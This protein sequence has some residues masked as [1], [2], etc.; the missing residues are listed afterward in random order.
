MT[1]IV[2]K[3]EIINPFEE[4]KKQR[5]R[6]LSDFLSRQKMPIDYYEVTSLLE[7]KYGIK[8]RTAKDYL[9]VVMIQQKLVQREG[10]I[11]KTE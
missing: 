4:A 8:L 7:A 9:R 10:K 6:W 3:K 2:T 1:E 5:L 11:Q